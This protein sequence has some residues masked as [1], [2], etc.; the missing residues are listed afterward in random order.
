SRILAVGAAGRGLC[1][2]FLG[3]VAVIAMGSVAHAQTT[4]DDLPPLPVVS[5][6]SHKSET[7]DAQ[8]RRSSFDELQL[9]VPATPLLCWSHSAAENP[10]GSRRSAEGTELAGNGASRRETAMDPIVGPVE[11]PRRDP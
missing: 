6:E 4:R 5:M 2:F 7:V 11:R 8:R 10:Q 9:L 1:H 3:M